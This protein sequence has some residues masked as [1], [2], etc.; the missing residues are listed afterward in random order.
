VV[1][2]EE[3]SRRLRLRILLLEEENDELHEQLAIA[4]DRIDDLEQ[5][6]KDLR[7]QIDYFE[8]ESHRQETQL[9]IKVRELNNIKVGRHKRSRNAEIDYR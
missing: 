4:D 7:E 6:C 8:A 9:R 2:K 3:G 1:I 5:E